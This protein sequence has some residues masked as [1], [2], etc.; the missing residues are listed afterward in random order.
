MGKLYNKTMTEPV[1]TITIVPIAQ[2][3]IYECIEAECPHCGNV[4]H[5]T[6]SDVSDMTGFDFEENGTLECDKCG[7]EFEYT[8]YDTNN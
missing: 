7:K 2:A 8:L 1:T 3:T 6:G 4:V 5:E